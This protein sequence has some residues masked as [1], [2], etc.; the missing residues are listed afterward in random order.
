MSAN[1]PTAKQKAL[2]SFIIQ[3]VQRHGYQPSQAEM[4]RH[5]GVS[6]TMV[7]SHLSALQRKGFIRLNP[8][9]ERAIELCGMQFRGV[10]VEAGAQG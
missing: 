5:L 2:L 6:K 10:P 8:G 1:E 4:A 7:V 3:C 9:M